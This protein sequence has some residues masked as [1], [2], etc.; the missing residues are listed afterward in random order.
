MQKQK[1]PWVAANPVPSVLY[2]DEGLR[3]IFRQNRV[4][5]A[6]LCPFLPSL[7]VLRVSVVNFRRHCK[8]ALPY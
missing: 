1:Y 3:M 7:R 8:F 2:D 4:S 6:V 5:H